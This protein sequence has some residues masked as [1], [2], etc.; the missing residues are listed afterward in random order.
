TTTEYWTYIDSVQV[1]LIPINRTQDIGVLEIRENK[2]LT[3]SDNNGDFAE[4]V[5]FDN[6]IIE[7]EVYGTLG[8]SFVLQSCT[9]EIDYPTFLRIEL[10]EQPDTML[11]G[12]NYTG[13]N[14]L[15]GVIDEVRI[16]KTISTD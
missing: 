11:I 14:R 3:Q 6:G 10:D 2:P 5:N 8:D 13:N 9:Y 1:S 7:L 16:L 15:D 4:V 12:T